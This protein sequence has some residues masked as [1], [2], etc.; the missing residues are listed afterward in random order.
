MQG[1]ETRT[2]P[3]R[4]LFVVQISGTRFDIKKIA[5]TEKGFHR[6][7]RWSS[8]CLISPM[9]M[10]MPQKILMEIF[11]PGACHSS[12]QILQLTIFGHPLTQAA[13]V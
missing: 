9:K 1:E 7:V 11:V 3:T 12:S 2:L 5:W 13:I 10:F 8:D 4:F 6:E